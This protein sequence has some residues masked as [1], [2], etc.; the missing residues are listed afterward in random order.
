MSS[1]VP[2]F[3]AML[4]AYVGKRSNSRSHMFSKAGVSLKPVFDKVSGLKAYIFI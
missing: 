4:L 1:S 2:M 3:L